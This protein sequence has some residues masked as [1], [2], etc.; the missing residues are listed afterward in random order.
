MPQHTLDAVYE[1]LSQLENDS[2]DLGTVNFICQKAGVPSRWV[3]AA[4]LDRMHCWKT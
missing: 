2:V 4:C 1:E 3:D